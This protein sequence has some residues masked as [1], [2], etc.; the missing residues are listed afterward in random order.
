MIVEAMRKFTLAS[1]SLWSDELILAQVKWLINHSEIGESG[2]CPAL[3]FYGRVL[4]VPCMRGVDDD[5]TIE[6][7]QSLCD[8]LK[9]VGRVG[10]Q[11]QKMLAMFL[12]EWLDQRERSRPTIRYESNLKPGVLVYVFTER[13]NKLSP[14]FR[15][16]FP[17]LSVRGRHVLVTTS[18]GVEM[19]WL[20]NVKRYKTLDPDGRRQ[21]AV[22]SEERTQQA[23]REENRVKDV[24][25]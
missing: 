1:G 5:I 20:G 22:A 18:S 13:V 21:A 23:L 8:L 3:L 17:V 16:P 24:L 11:R 25:P 7:P 2:I 15:G 9:I 10:S 19:H 14:T 6:Q 12:N 4:P